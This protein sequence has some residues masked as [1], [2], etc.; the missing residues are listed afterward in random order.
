MA[1][2]GILTKFPL[3]WAEKADLLDRSEWAAQLVLH[4]LGFSSH[5]PL[6]AFTSLEAYIW[7]INLRHL[8]IQYLYS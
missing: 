2:N 1:G 8:E 7:E 5:F 6:G 3:S 4:S